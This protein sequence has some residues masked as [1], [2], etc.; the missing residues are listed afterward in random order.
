MTV[1][2]IIAELNTVNH[3][4]RFIDG[5][6]ETTV[7]LVELTRKGF[8]EKNAFKKAFGPVEQAFARPNVS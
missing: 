5:H 7:S 3:A 1:S 8:A 6:A 2:K 4:R